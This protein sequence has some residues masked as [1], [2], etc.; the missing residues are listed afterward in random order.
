MWTFKAAVLRSYFVLMTSAMITDNSVFLNSQLPQIRIPPK[1]MLYPRESETREI[2]ELNG[3][4]KFR[5]DNSPSRN[6]G[7]SAKWYLQHLSETGPVIDMPVPSSFNDVTQD[8]TLRDFVGWVWYDREF[9]A[10]IGWRNPDVRVVLRFASAHYNTVVWLNGAQVMTHEGGHLPF[11]VEI[12][13]GVKY[14]APNLITVAVNN[15]LSPTTLPPGSLTFKNDPRNYPPGYFV[16][17][18]QFDFFNYAGIHRWVHLY[19]TP[20]VHISDIT[21]TTDFEGSTGIMNY[22]VLIGGLTSHSPAA[23]VEL[24]DPSEGGRVVAS[25]KSLS[26]VFTVSDVKPWW[27]Y[28]MSNNSAF[29]YTL[30][31]CVRNGATSDVYRLPVGFRTVSV[32]NKKLFINNK[33]FYFHGVNKHE[34]S[35]VRGKGLDLPLTIKDINLMKWMGANSLRTSHYPYA[36]EFL[37]LCD[38]H[39]IVVIDES[40]GVGIKLESN[41]G[42][43]SLAHHLEVMMEMYQRDKNRPSVVMWSVAN[44]PDSTLPT[45]PHY[46]G[47]VINFTRSLD[48][49]RLVTFVLGGTSVEREKVAQ[50]C[51][52]L[53]L[54][55]YFSWYSD[56]GHLELV[57]MQ[58]NTSLWDWHLKFNKTIIQSEYGADT[59]PGLHMDPPQMFTEDYQ[60]DMMAGYHA[61]FDIL[62]HNFLTGELIWNFADFMTVQSVTRVVGNKKGVFTRHRQP[63]AAAHLLRR[64]YLSLAEESKV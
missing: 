4:W 28:T 6:E 22:T 37:D 21:V 29:L 54:N 44:E 52:V 30:R 11:E 12:T 62:R 55:T 41:M 40:P 61:T 1:P 13:Q 20:R 45:A 59:I 2:K 46:F 7:F 60:C 14:M 33:P 26:G 15:T 53:C 42:P 58:S 19:T 27:P 64:R 10:P 31:V 57:E 18:V 39:G 38:Q 56:S 3:L 48:P 35:D 25:S 32:N 50:W 24:K 63:K 47:T 5:A 9:F 34:D 51:D 17:N 16:Q 43:V 23:T 8:R 36:E 49:T